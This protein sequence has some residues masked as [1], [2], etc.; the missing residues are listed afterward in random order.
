MRAVALILTFALLLG[1]PCALAEGWDWTRA[2]GGRKEDELVELI[3]AQDGL[4]AVGRTFSSDGDLS[5]RTQEGETGWALRLDAAGAPLWSLCTAHRGRAR[6]YGAFSHADGTFSCAL[7]GEDRGEE[8]LRIDARGRVT[9]RVERPE[10]GAVCGHGAQTVAMLGATTSAEGA[11]AM[12]LTVGHE[13]GSRCFPLLLETGEVLPGASAPAPVPGEILRVGA[14]GHI[15]A[16]A[17]GEGSASVLLLTAGEMDAPRQAE[18]AL[19]GAPLSPA[20]AAVLED[21]SAL[22]CA[23]TPDGGWVARVSAEGEPLFSVFT[24]EAALCVSATR[25]GFAA[26]TGS[27]VLFLSEEGDL[28]GTRPARPDEGVALRDLA[29]L[30]DGVA[31]LGDE[32]AAHARQAHVA[33]AGGY[34]A[35]VGEAFAR[36]LYARL[37]SRLI[38]AE[39]TPDGARL[40]VQDADGQTVSLLVS[41]DGRTLEETTVLQTALPG[42]LG[43]SSGEVLCEE[44]PGYALVTRRNAYGEALWRT[45]VPIQTAADSLTL[46][47]ALEEDG[48]LLL[49]GCY[50]TGEGDGAQRQA[51]LVWL[52]GEGVLRAVSIAPEYEGFL[53]ACRRE[54]ELLLLCAA[55]DGETLVV[56][57]EDGG[58]FAELSRLEFALAQGEA[59]L[60]CDGGGALTAAGTALHAGRR[61]ALLQRVP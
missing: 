9:A 24:E 46:S 20:D 19:G 6:L 29:A 32:D 28:L 22:F 26:A 35:E 1:A 44:G 11:P 47:F 58:A 51:V 27:G 2:Y 7:G 5:S 15:A 4:L 53:A 43:L 31:L 42:A 61:C 56:R 16:I 49:G 33:A 50:S 40:L 21:G 39:Q 54:G 30:G 41:P 25:A 45:R 17:G 14:A 52:G 38:R 8:W 57:R 3:P 55:H 36:A 34:T 12:A 37:D 13:D 18:I 10:A 59:A 48:N 23:Q 60:L